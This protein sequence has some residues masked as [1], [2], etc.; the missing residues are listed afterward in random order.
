MLLALQW[1][2]GHSPGQTARWSPPAG[3][4]P[5]ASM[6]GR[7]LARPDLETAMQLLTQQSGFNG[8]PDTRP[9][10]RVRVPLGAA[11]MTVLQWRAGHS[12]G[13][14]TT[15]RQQLLI[16]TRASMEGRTLARPDFAK[17]GKICSICVASMEGRTLARPDPSFAPSHPH[18][19]ARFNGGPDTRPARPLQEVLELMEG[20]G[21]SM[22]GRTL[23]RPDRRYRFFGVHGAFRFN[24]GPDTRP[25]RPLARSGALDLPVSGRLRAVVE[26]R[27]SKVTRFCCQAAI[28]LVP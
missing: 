5:L 7:T 9:A 6:E 11:A 13:Q 27:G 25:A 14:T 17:A 22:E 4:Q 18:F 15:T 2:A 23:A 8:G 26:V 20:L 3:E 21:A 12:P 1:R 19:L 28:R 16:W 24:G 10:R